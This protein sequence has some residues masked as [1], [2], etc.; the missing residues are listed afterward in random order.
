VAGFEH[1]IA[2]GDGR[3]RLRASD[4]DRERVIDRLK[5]AYVYG[6]VT[7]AE[8]DERVS[9]TFGARTC[10]ELAVITSD[11]PAGLAAAPLPLT[12][13]AARPSA[14]VA[15]NVTRADRAIMASATVAILALV[16]SVFATAAQLPIAGPLVLAAAANAVLTVLLFRSQARSQR[17]KG[18]R[19]QLPPQ[20]GADA[21]ASAAY[22]AISAT[23]AERVPRAG[24]P[25]SRNNAD[26]ALR[27]SLHPQLS[28]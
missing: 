6:L 12:P 21:G 5:A 18:R 13:A 7:K 25:R 28:C 2:A 17:A 15:A 10:G 8:F 22:R 16:A 27:H 9:Q 19:G 26:A 23:S 24:K 3:G 14:R 11:V 20:R 4:A 1:E